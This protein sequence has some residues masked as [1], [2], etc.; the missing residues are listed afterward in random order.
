MYFRNV[1]SLASVMETTYMDYMVP[2][3]VFFSGLVHLVDWYDPLTSGCQFGYWLQ[4]EPGDSF[5]D[6]GRVRG[7]SYSLIIVV[8]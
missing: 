3:T 6:N 5:N 2:W 7:V 8:R 1:A 4:R